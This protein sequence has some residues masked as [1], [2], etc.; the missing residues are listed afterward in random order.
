MHRIKFYLPIVMLGLAALFMAGCYTAP[1]STPAE[2][3]DE[4][5]EVSLEESQQMTEEFVRHSPTFVYDGIEE[6]LRLS[7]TLTARCPSC[8]MFIF[9]FNS[10]HAGY[11][12]RRGQAVAQ[13]ITPHRAAISVEQGIVTSAVMDDRWDMINQKKV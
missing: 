3:S 4:V 8:W 10:R 11:G 7:D 12:N 9:E 2:P 5:K 13:A 1:A 6:T